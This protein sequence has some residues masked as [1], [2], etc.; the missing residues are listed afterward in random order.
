MTPA[1]ISLIISLVEEAI[2]EY[3]AIAADLTSIFSKS[4]PTPDDWNLLRAKV[5]VK[6]YADYVPASAIPAGGISPA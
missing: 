4:N 5:L 2:K 3:P 1:A 6:S